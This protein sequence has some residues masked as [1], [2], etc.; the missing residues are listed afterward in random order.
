MKLRRVVLIILTAGV[1][2]GL[3]AFVHREFFSAKAVFERHFGAPIPD[4]VTDISV[5]GYTALA[6]SDKTIT[7]RINAD[8]LSKLI[9]QRGFIPR[10][11]EVKKTDSFSLHIKHAK[12]MGVAGGDYFEITKENGLIYYILITDHDSNLVYYHYS[13]T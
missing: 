3:S 9:R 4:S 10:T 6:G 1:S 13:K 2:C 11:K 8:D 12:Q 5:S 7:F